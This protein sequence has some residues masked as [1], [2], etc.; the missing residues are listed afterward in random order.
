MFNW[1]ALRLRIAHG[2]GGEVCEGISEKACEQAPNN[3]LRLLLVQVCTKLG[4]ALTSSKIVLPWLL[5]SL[6]APAFMQGLLVPIRESGSLIPQLIIGS[7]VRRYPVRKPF[8]VGGC[9]VQALA[10]AA[11]AG[12]A[13]CLSGGL[14]GAGV[15][16]CLLV[17]SL[18]RGFC[19]VASK[20]ITGK[21]IPK[22]R[23]GRL[24]GF[25][26][27]AAGLVTVAVGLLLL[28]GWLTKQVSLAWLLLAASICW[29]VAAG[30][31]ARVVEFS[32]EA[33]KKQKGVAAAVSGLS[34]LRSDA[35]FRRFVL[36]RC[37]LLSS[38]LAA[39]YFVMLAQQA[40]TGPGWAGLG[41]FIV[42]SGLASLFSGKVWGKFADLSSRRVMIITAW[43]TSLL[44]GL[45]STLGF[46]AGQVNAY[47]CMALFFLLAVV[48][49]GVRLGRKTYVVDIAEGNLRTDYVTV[50]NS[51]IGVILLVLG[52]CGALVAQ[53]SL[54][55]VLAFFALTSFAAALVAQALPEAE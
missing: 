11:M 48:H 16:A 33:E 49:Q 10:V 23:R 24:G 29:L 15:M 14:A 4:D 17:F 39:P 53:L 13:W 40:S 36:A 1:Q 50:S 25:S 37:L 30:V 46:F 21:A 38:A 41:L 47:V 2:D 45:G 5:M 9:L 19:S 35:A 42:I 54:V 55:V 34:L 26:A 43:L 6:G 18:A 51:V 3:F 12:C 31:F 7:V 20:D 44:C 32:G 28:A 27:S 22:T 8:F 52:L